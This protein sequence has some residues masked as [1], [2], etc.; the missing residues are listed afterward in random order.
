M[1]GP[2]LC[3]DRHATLLSALLL[4][5]C[6]SNP[7][8]PED[9]ADPEPE[10]ARLVEWDRWQRVTDPSVDA[11]ADLRPADA[12]CD[13]AGWY[14]E[15]IAQTLEV[16]T[17]LCD[18]V[19]LWQPSLAPIEPGDVVTVYAFHDVLSAAEPAQGYLGLAF[20]GEIEW[21][22]TIPIPGDPGSIEQHFVIDRAI[23]AGAEVQYHIHNHGPNTWE[24]LAVMVTPQE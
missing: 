10:P 12:V 20:D 23:P 3:L 18:Y 5:G 13:D 8:E 9:E 1:I 17:E 14:P 21:S 19:T 7:S 6:P 22:H 11:F 15:P 2:V 16:Q 24:L 4:S